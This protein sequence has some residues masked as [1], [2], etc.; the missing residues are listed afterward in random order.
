VLNYISVIYNE[1][2]VVENSNREKGITATCGE[3]VIIDKEMHSHMLSAMA[4]NYPADWCINQTSDLAFGH[5]DTLG[6]PSVTER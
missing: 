6:Y 3:N 5:L 1:V 2:F 4:D